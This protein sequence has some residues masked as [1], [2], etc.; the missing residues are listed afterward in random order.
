[1]QLLKVLLAEQGLFPKLS[2]LPAYGS[3]EQLPDYVMLIGDQALEFLH[4]PGQH[5]VMDLG[6]SWFELT[7]LPFVYAVWALRRGIDQTALG[8]LLRESKDFGLETL[9]HIVRERT[10]FSYEFRKDYLTWHIH[11][12][13][14]TDEKRG[15]SRFIELLRKHGSLP[16]FDPVWVG[17]S[18]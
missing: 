14:G 13:L 18:R 2:P 8:R 4:A 1:V 6:A 10:E 17:S 16:V 12:H 9:E 5:E 15:V 3:P 11:Y 7:G